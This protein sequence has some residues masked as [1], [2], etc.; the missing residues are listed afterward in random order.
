MRE[1]QRVRE[2]ERERE[3]ESEMRRFIN[4]RRRWKEGRVIILK[5]KIN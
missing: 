4:N 2:R 3:R 1:G 5:G